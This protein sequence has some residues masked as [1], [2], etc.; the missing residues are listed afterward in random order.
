MSAAQLGALRVAWQTCYFAFTAMFHPVLSRRTEYDRYGGGDSDSNDSDWGGAISAVLLGILV[1]SEVARQGRIEAAGRGPHL[2]T[3]PLSVSVLA[4]GKKKKKAAKKPAAKKEKAE[5]AAPRAKKAPA[6]RKTNEDG[7]E[8]TATG[9]PLALVSRVRRGGRLRWNNAV[10]RR[11]LRPPRLVRPRP[12]G[13]RKRKDTGQKRAASCAARVARPL[14]LAPSV[15]LT[16]PPAISLTPLLLT[17]FIAPLLTAVQPPVH[18]RGGEALP[19]GPRTLRPQLEAGALGPLPP[20]AS[21]VRATAAAGFQHALAPLSPQISAH[22]QGSRDERAVSSH[23]QK[24]FI[25]L[26][27]QG[28]P[29]PAK[30]AES[31]EGYT[32][33]GKPLDPNSSAARQYGFKPD[34]LQARALAERAHLWRAIHDSLWRV[35]ARRADGRIFPP[36]AAP[37]RP[38]R[39]SRRRSG[40]TCSAG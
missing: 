18:P 12:P 39:S 5:G 23:A 1:S 20:R 26:C 14:P 33:S 32:L 28:R 3:K 15:S 21:P 16:A 35:G 17:T 6:E 24:H 4:G 29:L 7:E 37:A 34:T 19:R 8:L 10:T 31:G 13:R 25:R 9:A 36:L 22:M 27:L 30:V 38:R 11:P 2:A 40:R